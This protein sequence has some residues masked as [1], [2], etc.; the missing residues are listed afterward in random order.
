MTVHDP[1]NTTH[2]PDMTHHD[3][4]ETTIVS[5]K[6]P[7]LGLHGARIG[8]RELFGDLQYPV[9]LNHA[10]ISPPSLP[11]RQNVAATLDGYAQQGLHQ[12]TVEQARRDGVREDLAALLSVS[13]DDVALVANTST[14]VATIALCFPWQPGDTVVLLR[15]EFPTNVT[16]WLQAAQREG[17]NV[18]WL[19]AERFR[20]RPDD[21]LVEL[22]KVLAAGAAL[23]AISAVQFSTGHR[24]PLAAIGRLCQEHGTQLFVDAIQALGGIELDAAALGIDYLAAGSHKWLMAP[25][26]TGV[27]YVNPERAASLRPW[28][29]AWMSHENAF[30]FLFAGPGHLQYDRPIQRTARFAE[31]G[32]PNVLGIAG[33]Q[34]SVGILRSLGIKQIAEHVQRW[35]DRV[36]GP[37][38]NRGFVSARTS[39]VT[40]RSSILSFWPPNDTTAPQWSAALL[41]VGISCACPDGW[42]RLAP[43]WPNAL[44][45]SEIVIAAVDKILAEG[46]PMPGS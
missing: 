4:G 34:A 46:G 10:A 1:S 38:V 14:G 40:G 20:L 8:S 35:H 36:E 37:L 6:T 11:V 2:D 45:E 19:D 27:L 41:K 18:H 12:Y 33:M 17:L 24:M 32:A 28:T 30:E 44:E 26:G 29:A 39:Y 23:L 31:G 5:A 7:N 3:P 13:A 15:G 21:A 25:E 22:A 9:Y 43:H 16:P 42:L